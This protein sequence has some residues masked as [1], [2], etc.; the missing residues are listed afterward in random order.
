MHQWVTELKQ[1]LPTDTPIV[2]AGN[3]SDLHNN[4]QIDEETVKGYAKS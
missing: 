2:I 1:Y 3:K 4:T